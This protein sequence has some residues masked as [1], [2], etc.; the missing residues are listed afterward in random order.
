MNPSTKS[1]TVGWT[2]FLILD[3][4]TSNLDANT[5]EAITNVLTN[6]YK[7]LTVIVIAHRLSTIRQADKIAVIE[8][9]KV[10]EFGK[11]SELLKKK[12][13]YYDLWVSQTGIKEGDVNEK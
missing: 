10:I 6:E 11:H 13:N 5:E 1:S 9:G 12:G 4:A 7:N 3:E 2:Y 8:K